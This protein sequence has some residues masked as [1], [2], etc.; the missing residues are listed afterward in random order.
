M[1]DQ[2]STNT[3]YTLDKTKESLSQTGQS[4]N[5]H[6]VAAAEATKKGAIK[7]ADATKQATIKAAD[8][9]KQATIKAADATKKGFQSSFSYVSSYFKS[10][11]K[12]SE[13]E[14]EKE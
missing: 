3:T 1:L 4:I 10:G 11:D 8:A 14:F 9:T 2:I 5:K 6:S 12:E 7:A 13:M